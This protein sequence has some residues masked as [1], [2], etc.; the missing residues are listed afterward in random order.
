MPQ[1][2]GTYGTQVGR[3]RKRKNIVK[4]THKSTTFKGGKV[5]VKR[6][7]NKDGSLKKVVLREGGKRTVV[8]PKRD[9]RKSMLNTMR[10]R[11]DEKR[12]GNTSIAPRNRLVSNVFKSKATPS[13]MRFMT[14]SK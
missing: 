12:S 7:L 3:P 10:N 5:K 13:V 9:A 8:K 6:K 11:R 2:E 4:S 1:G 14:K